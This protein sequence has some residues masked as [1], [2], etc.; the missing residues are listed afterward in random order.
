MGLILELAAVRT[1]DLD[2]AVP[3]VF[4][5][6]DTTMGFE[7]AVSGRRRREI[8]ATMDGD[9]AIVIDTACV[10]SQDH[11]YLAE[12]SAST[13]LFLVRIFDEP[14]ALRYRNGRRTM[15]A[16]GLEACLAIAPPDTI[17]DG[18]SC[19]QSL[20][21]EATG[22]SF[23]GEDLWNAKFTLFTLA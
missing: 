2:L 6:T 20:L 12:A 22:V 9:W 18:E 3:D 15:E 17:R 13:D 5:P 1:D 4:E 11:F 19:A 23:G 14:L 7:D 8:C 10:M 16:T 21:F